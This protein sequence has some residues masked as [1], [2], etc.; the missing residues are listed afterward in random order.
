L[1]NPIG[2]RKRKYEKGGQSENNDRVSPN[3][4][5]VTVDR[6]KNPT[7]PHS[8]VH[9]EVFGANS[10]GRKRGWLFEIEF[11]LK[12]VNSGWGGERWERTEK[13]CWSGSEKFPRQPD[14][15]RTD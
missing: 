10:H 4:R 14:D 7:L 12:R 6:R 2:K 5:L 11:R 1:S 9:K 13:K 8:L 3:I 15:D